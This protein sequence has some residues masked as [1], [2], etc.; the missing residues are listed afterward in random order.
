MRFEPHRIEFRINLS[1]RTT[2]GPKGTLRRRI[3]SPRALITTRLQTASTTF[4]FEGLSK[5]STCRARHS[6]FR[7]SSWH[8]NLT[9]LP[10]AQDSALFQFRPIPKLE[11]F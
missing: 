11:S 9:Y 6:G 4:E 7:T 10:W 3:V 5:T 2:P 1:P 8:N